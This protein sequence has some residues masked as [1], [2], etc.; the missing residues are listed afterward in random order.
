[1]LLS[2]ITINRNNASGL[3][4]TIRSVLSQTWK[5]FE[6]IIVDGASSDDSV[7]VI[8]TYASLIGER[9]KW[10]SEPDTGIY[11]AMN[12]GIRMS[13]GEYLLFLNSGDFLAGAS[14][15][16]DLH[17]ESFT[18][19][20]VVAKCNVLEGDKV[21]WTFIPQKTYTFG[22]IYFNGI[23]HQS[24]FIKKSLFEKCGLYDESY[25]YNGDTEFWYRA[26]IDNQASTQSSDVVVT[27]YGL[28]GLSDV[29]K[30]NP[31]FN[32]EHKRILSNPLFEKF[33]PDYYNW[34][35]DKEWIRKYQVIEQY[36]SILRFVFF[37]D[38]QKRRL[39]SLF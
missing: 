3:D 2:I 14:V 29:L 12:K 30:D 16:E 11:N 7:K 1:M 32:D 23:A 8:Q 10:I 9:L 33:L 18:A 37:I 38:R 27:N 26:I 4:K 5:D 13:S 39:R 19:D 34:R 21:V 17:I 24:S 36:P 20:I 22:G 6:Y 35:K 28:G 25:K 15:L 31:E